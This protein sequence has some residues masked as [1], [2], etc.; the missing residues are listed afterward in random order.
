MGIINKHLNPAQT[1]LP[2]VAFERLPVYEDPR[3]DLADDHYLW[4]Q[5]LRIAYEF[6]REERAQSAEFCGVLNGMRCGGTRL[7]PGKNGWVLR[8]DIDE[9]G[10][11]A[12][13]SQTEYDTYKERYLVRWLEWLRF[14]LKKL[15]EKAPF[16]RR[17]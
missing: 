10:V 1:S 13:Q 11:V 4:N 7:R 16:N 9:S 5:L 15:N 2:E 12:W 17:S 3:P 8:P 6:N 14:A